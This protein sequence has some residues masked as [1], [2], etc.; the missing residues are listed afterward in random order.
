MSAQILLFCNQNFLAITQEKP[1]E[2][3]AVDLHGT[4]VTNCLEKIL[5]KHPYELSIRPKN[6]GTRIR[7]LNTESF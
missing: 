6:Q 1:G 3:P 4:T 2:E 5:R 7:F